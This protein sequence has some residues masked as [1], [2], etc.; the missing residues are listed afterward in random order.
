MR[1]LSKKAAFIAVV[2]TLCLLM[3]NAAYSAA[4]S[5]V[6]LSGGKLV[7]TPYANQG[8]TNA[9]N[10]I[11]DF[12]YCGYMGGGV[13]LPNVPVKKS[14]SPVS[15]DNTTHIQSAIDYV[16]G[17]TP[18]ANGFRGAVY[19]N[20]GTYNVNGPLT[21]KTSGVVLKGAGQGTNGTR[22]VDTAAVQNDFLTITGSS[23]AAWNEVAGT[24][25]AITTSY[26]PT[27]TKSFTIASASG[28]S[29]GDCII[30][31]R[32]P[33][34]TWINDL[35]MAQYGWTADAYQVG[36]ER[37]ITAI[38]GNQITIDVPIVQAM[39]TKYG[40]G[41]VLK[42]TAAGR[43][44]Q[45]G[46]ENIRF[47]SVYA[48]DTDENHGWSAIR[49]KYVED[50]WVRD[51]TAVYFGYS[52]VRL[53]DGVRRVTVQDCAM[54]DAKS[55]ITGGRRY[56]FCIEGASSLNLIQRCYTKDGRHDYVTGSRVPGPNAFIDSYGETCYDDVG[57]HHRYA[58]GLLFDNIQAGEIRVWNRGASGTGHG[59]SGAQTV[60]WNCE[61]KNFTS[62]SKNDIRV[63]SPIGAKNFGIG[64]KAQTQNGAGLYESWGTPVIPRSLYLQQ[65][66]DRLGQT[67]VDNIAPAA[68]QNGSVWS[69]LASW[70][71][72]GKSPLAGT[73]PEQPGNLALNKNVTF[74][75][76][77][78]GNEATHAV[79][80]NTVTRWSAQT[81]PQSIQVDLGAIYNVNKTEVAPYLDRAYRYKV[82][83]STDGINYT[84]VVDRT[85]N[86]TGGAVLADTFTGINARYVKLTV[87]GCYNDTTTWASI[88]EFRVFGIQ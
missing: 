50:S 58:T 20:A 87:T 55:Q 71:G 66:K 72:E 39:E 7:Y 13:A 1:L 88:N 82:E 73:V 29:V 63:D 81:F 61:N 18:D 56:S 68:Q 12:S 31:L 4:S 80:G 2:T 67:A 17:L 69:T 77:Q 64:C 22:V 27:G 40:G 41:S 33:N 76:E 35:N 5:L 65:L 60:L 19:L 24:R 78:I 52:C 42:Y 75:G 25:Q 8:Q 10:T 34:D 70:K 28:Y 23:T 47:E 74:S 45:C 15:G 85:G 3:T 44:S 86:T 46:V 36:Y 21:I 79:D 6:Y 11:P 38:S 53:V 32:T 37:K 43:I 30:V 26:V 62:T 49:M 51:V 54:K 16:S 14:I 83:V 59:W 9:V 48:N 84:Q 57:P